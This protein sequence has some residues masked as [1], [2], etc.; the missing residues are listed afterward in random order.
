MAKMINT[1][2]KLIICDETYVLHMHLLILLHKFKYWILHAWNILSQVPCQTFVLFIIHHHTYVIYWETY[3][4]ANYC[5][6]HSRTH[7]TSINYLVQID[8]PISLYDL[9][10]TL[11]TP[12]GSMILMRPFLSNRPLKIPRNHSSPRKIFP[13]QP[14]MF[15]FSISPSGHLPM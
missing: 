13:I 11:P 5:N 3:F 6:I 9:N 4:D 10:D 14:R 15:H 8:T 12:Q 2:Q 1:H 7:R